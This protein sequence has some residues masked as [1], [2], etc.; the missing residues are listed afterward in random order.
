MRWATSYL[1]LTRPF[2]PSAATV[3]LRFQFRY[4]APPQPRACSQLDP[5]TLWF[6]AAGL[7]PSKAAA[8]A[9]KWNRSDVTQA[10]AST[11][12]AGAL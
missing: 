12:P 6:S 1:L 7:A 9:R 5:Q 2:G 8:R 4:A 10:L 11:R 3:E